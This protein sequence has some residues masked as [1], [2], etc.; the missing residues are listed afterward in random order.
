M[1]VLSLFDGMSCGQIALNKAEIKYNKYYASE[2]KS[3]AIKVTQH[4]YPE[5]IQLGKAENIKY[6]HLS[7]ID[8]LLGGSP[9]QDY[10]RCNSDRK[11]IEGEKSSL[12][13][14]YFKAFEVCKPKYFLLENVIMDTKD[15]KYISD[16]LGV[17]PIRINSSRVSA[18]LRDR[19]YW[20][21]IQEED[22]ID[23]FGR[24]ISMPENKGIELQDILDSGK[25]ISKKA[26][27]LR[28]SEHKNIKRNG[29]NGITQECIKKRIDMKIE[30]FIFEDNKYRLLNKNERARLQCVPESYINIL[31]EKEAA[32]L[33]GDGWTIDVIVHIL[34][35]TKKELNKL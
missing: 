20:T 25:S 26:Y 22:Y 31:D 18:Q 34:K 17:F 29:E 21:N 4:N 8:L 15:A 1:N 6:H 10:S 2:I 5:T 23:F 30:N 32:S 3:H 9:C 27:C 13:N 24:N 16:R 35:N 14:Y 11:G 19:L 7:S 28:Q 12:I 33:L